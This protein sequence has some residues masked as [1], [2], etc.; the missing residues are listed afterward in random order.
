MKKIMDDRIEKILSN[1]W[2]GYTRSNQ[3]LNSLEMLL[4]FPPSDRM[5]NL[6]IIGESNNGKTTIAKRFLNLNP[7]YLSTEI[8]NETNFTFEAIVRPVV[9]IQCPHIPHEKRLYYNI[10]DEMNF[11]YRKTAKA[12]DL[13]KIVISALRDLKVKVLVLDEIHHILSGSPIKQREFLSLIKYISNQARISLVG[14]GTNEAN[15]ALNA[16]NQLA[17]RFDKMVIS[18]WKYDAD[19]IR[20][21]ATIEKI[22]PLN[23]GSN[24]IESKI[25]KELFR[26]SYGI[27]GEVIKICKLSAVKAIESG[28]ERITI[29]I[30]TELQYTSPYANPNLSIQ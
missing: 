20:L 3:I 10:L 26:M 21:L 24:L 28:E 5:Q 25:S 1:N 18:R 23:N 14:L 13:G 30:L 6:L 29:E 2:I 11:P 27:I 15:Y 17:T 8:N 19:F 9:M 16:D 7:P 22:L 12:E 4:R